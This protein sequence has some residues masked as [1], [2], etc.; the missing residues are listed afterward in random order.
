MR[1]KLLSTNSIIIDEE[2]R[3]TYPILYES[4]KKSIKEI[5]LVEPPNLFFNGK[6]YFLLTGYRRFQALLE[7]NVKKAYFLILEKDFTPE[8]RIERTLFEN[9]TKRE[10]TFY[11]KFIFLKKMI[12]LSKEKFRK[13]LKILGLKE[14]QEETFLREYSKKT[15]LLM[16]KN[17]LNPKSL[18]M[19][20][21]LTNEEEEKLFSFFYK[22]N[23]THS[24]IREAISLYLRAREMRKNFSV[25]NKNKED[26]FEEIRG[27][28]Y[29][30]V[31]KLEERLNDLK[32]RFKGVKIE[33]YPFF[34]KRKL[35]FLLEFESYEELRKK[36]KSSLKSLENLEG[37]FF[38]E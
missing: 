16:E 1:I 21:Y 38:E 7:L 9:I 4:L 17:K 33:G 36:L 34:E 35:K 37:D 18:F 10:L 19:V 2:Y 3:I 5:G 20:K 6:K 32:K 12:K 28:V 13:Y 8:E 22:N 11:E 14:L 15:Y 26:F 25:E 31:K 23:F 27:I 30:T 24:E 29:P